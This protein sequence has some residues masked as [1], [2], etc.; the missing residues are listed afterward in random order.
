MKLD[1]EQR[2]I[3][4][5]EPDGHV[6]IRGVA[7]SGKT[8]VAVRRVQFLQENYCYEQEDHILYV[9]YNETLNNYIK[10]KFAQAQKN[11][12]I[13]QPSLF[14]KTN[15]VH[16]KHIDQLMEPYFLNY[17]KRHNKSYKIASEQQQKNALQRAIFSTRKRYEKIDLI[18]QTY[19]E[20]LLDEVKWIKACNIND[21]NTYQTI[22]RIGRTD[23]SE[24]I[25]QRLRKNSQTREAIFALMEMYDHYLSH[26]SLVDFMTMNQ[27]ALQEA[28]DGNYPKY[29]HIIIDDDQDLSKVQLKFISEFYRNKPYSSLMFIGDNTQSIYPYSWLGK[30][31]PHSSIGFPMSGRRR[32]LAKNYRTTTEISK[33]AYRLIEKDKQIQENVDYVSPLLIDR[34]GDE[35]VY[36]AFKNERKQNEFLTDEIKRLH[37]KF[38]YEDICIMT[39]NKHLLQTIKQTFE[40]KNIPYEILNN[41][42]SQYEANKVKLTTLHSVKGLEFNVVFLPYLDEGIIPIQMKEMDNDLTVET[43]ERKLL[44]VGMTRATKLLYMSSTG[45]PSR[46]LKDID[47]H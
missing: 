24:G 37:K 41:N 27:F 18:D 8:T 32:T 33:A 16:I 31:R 40:K 38:N 6:L 13:R 34:H 19:R 20:F 22:D 35:P 45:K 44:Y 17:Q 30:G 7:G 3:I 25:P 28:K 21:L 4:E 39:R 9:T 29:T 1:I 2:R 47:L 10:Y 15:Q 42:K 36:Q 14:Q 46:F 43:E 26:A 23:K 11:N 5:F 12:P